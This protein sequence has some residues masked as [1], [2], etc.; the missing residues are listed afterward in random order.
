MNGTGGICRRVKWDPFAIC[1]DVPITGIKEIF[2]VEVLKSEVY[3]KSTDDENLRREP[4]KYI[5][6]LNTLR[7]EIE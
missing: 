1:G 4:N 5:I 2:D 7:D 6:D 3:M